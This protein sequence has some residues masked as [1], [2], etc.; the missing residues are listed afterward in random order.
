[1][2]NVKFVKTIKIVLFIPDI[3]YDIF[4]ELLISL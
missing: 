2:K 4:Q 3:S 1:M